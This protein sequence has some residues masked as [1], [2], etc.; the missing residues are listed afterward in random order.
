MKPAW[1]SAAAIVLGLGAIP[2]SAQMVV[3]AKSGVVNYTEGAVRLNGQPVESTVTHYPDIKENGVLSTAEGRAEIL[4]T[5][6]VVLR[7]AENGSVKMLTN[8]LIDTRLELMSGS[9]VV[10]ADQ[11]AKET[12]VTVVVRDG[13]VSIVKPGLYRFDTEPARLKVF[14]GSAE[15][16]TAGVSTPVGSGRMLGLEGGK[17]AVEKF[18]A[19]DTDALDHW[20]RRRG[21]YMSIANVSSAT[22]LL[23]TGFS[24][25]G[26]VPSWRYN[27][28]FGMNTYMPCS[29]YLYSPYGYGF[30]SPLM[31]MP[32]YWNG[33]LFG[34]GGYRSLATAYGPVGRLTATSF[35][36]PG[37]VAS[38][39]GRVSA[40]RAGGVV[41]GHSGGFSGGAAGGGGGSGGHGGGF[42]GGGSGG[43]A[44]GGGGG[45]GGAH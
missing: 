35:G 34:G 22:S 42:S 1:I 36:A 29:G 40:A 25:M 21:E 38:D 26:C 8:R 45:H 18:N 30:W 16:E 7:L 3:A 4:L 20:S 24:P 6:G 11:V 27:M 19:E 2:A 17:Q 15:V 13:A 28:W 12:K 14:R 5:P 44:G 31:V 33:A 43:H 9:A 39:G 32:G 23:N 37:R 10:E 41:A